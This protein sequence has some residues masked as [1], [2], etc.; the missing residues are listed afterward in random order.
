MSVVHGIKM[1]NNTDDSDYGELIIL[2]G[3]ISGGNNAWSDG[4]FTDDVTGKTQIQRY[5]CGSWVHSECAGMEK[6]VRI[7]DF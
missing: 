1:G 5:K 2:P 3:K 6:E 7:C 4:L